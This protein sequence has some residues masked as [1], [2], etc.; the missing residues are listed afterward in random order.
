MYTYEGTHL[1]DNAPPPPPPH[2]YAGS[3]SANQF[4]CKNGNCV[5]SF[6][7]CNY[8]NDCE[9]NSDEMG[10]GESVQSCTLMCNVH[11]HVCAGGGGGRI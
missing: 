7:V 1:R 11:V 4:R 10:C 3:C 9:D 8:A 5:S 2:T 6:S